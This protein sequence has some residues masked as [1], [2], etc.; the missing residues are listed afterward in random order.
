MTPRLSAVRALDHERDVEAL[1]VHVGEGM[2]GVD[3]ERRQ[4]RIDAGAEQGVNVAPLGVVQ[5][6]EPHPLDPAGGQ[7]RQHVGSENAVLLG[8]EF[9]HPAFDGGELLGGREPVRPVVLR[10]DPGIHLLLQAGHP[11]LEELVQ[12]GAEDRE[13][14]EALEPGVRRVGRLFQHAGV[15]LEPGELPVQVVVRRV[16]GQGALGHGYFLGR[17]QVRVS[18]AWNARSNSAALRFASSSSIAGSRVARTNMRTQPS[19]T[20]HRTPW[21]TCPWA[22]SRPS[23][24]RSTPLNRRT[25]RRSPRSSRA[26]FAWVFFGGG[27]MRAKRRPTSMRWAT[28]A[29][30]GDAGGY[31]SSIIDSST[32]SRMPRSFTSTRWVPSRR[33]NRAIAATPA[34]MMSARRGLSPA[35]WRRASSGVSRSRSRKRTTSARLMA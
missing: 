22:R 2:T 8:D 31:R 29:R 30:G 32:P 9:V 26:K 25:R 20:R 28:G 23:A 1:V 5:V 4:D 35:I 17:D 24:T 10:L 7:P 14:F 3:G 12:V 19:P 13:E 6:L 27:R 11:D 21:S 33:I 34:T 15:E 18:S 16:G